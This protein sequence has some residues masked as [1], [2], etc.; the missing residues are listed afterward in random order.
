MSALGI[1]LT[2]G[3]IV[4]VIGAGLAFTLVR[5][6]GRRHSDAIAAQ[7]SDPQTI[8]ADADADAEAELTLV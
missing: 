4:T 6:A 2:V 7:A 3:G 8:S 1:G 5:Q